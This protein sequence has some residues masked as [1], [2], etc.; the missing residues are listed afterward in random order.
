MEHLTGSPA[1]DQLLEDADDLATRALRSFHQ[2]IKHYPNHTEVTA[3]PFL[4][5]EW[6]K[7]ATIAESYA[8][9][10]NDFYSRKTWTQ[11]AVQLLIGAIRENN[12]NCRQYLMRISR[13][14]LDYAFWIHEHPQEPLVTLSKPSRMFLEM[15]QAS[16]AGNSRDSLDKGL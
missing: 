11:H 3:E 2:G 9:L 8:R 13:I 4:D 7:M 14:Y 1:A 16:I 5:L 10:L 6:S 12:K 15:R